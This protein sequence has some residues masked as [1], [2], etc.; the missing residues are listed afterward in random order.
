VYTATVGPHAE[1]GIVWTAFALI[2]LL[3]LAFA[4]LVISG[5]PSL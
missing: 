4:A 5:Y 1:T 2:A 3:L